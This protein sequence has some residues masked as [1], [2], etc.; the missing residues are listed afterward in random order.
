MLLPMPFAGVCRLFSTI[1]AT[2]MPPITT[3]PANATHSTVT[4]PFSEER[5]PLRTSLTFT[6]THSPL[7]SQHALQAFYRANERVVSPHSHARLR[8]RCYSTVSPL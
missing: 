8:F 4:R 2:V 6:T 3:A 7:L 5:K 1:H